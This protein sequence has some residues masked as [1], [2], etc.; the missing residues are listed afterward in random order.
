[1]D[2]SKFK[3]FLLLIM[4]VSLLSLSVAPMALAVSGDLE[5]GIEDQL[6]PIRQVYDPQG[7]VSPD[8]LSEIIAKIIKT[9][10]GFLGMIFLALIIYAGFRWMTAAG[11]DENISKAKKI[12][13]AALIGLVIILI[14]YA[15]T[16]YIFDVLF[17][18]TG[19]APN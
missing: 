7:A 17:D 15:I 11:N 13:S 19:I 3:I 2:K 10:L 18:A 1:M 16:V 12:L 14:S 9:V 4:A 5:D 8:S 6:R